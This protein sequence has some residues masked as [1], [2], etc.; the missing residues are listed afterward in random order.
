MPQSVGLQKVNANW[1]AP[2]DCKLEEEG[3]SRGAQ[4]VS[5]FRVC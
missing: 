4:E 5:T 2:V 3:H 1:E